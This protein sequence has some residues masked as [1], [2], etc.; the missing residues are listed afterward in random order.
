MQQHY[1][2]YHQNVQNGVDHMVIVSLVE[3]ALL[4][5]LFE[6]DERYMYVQVR[7][8][9]DRVLLKFVFKTQQPDQH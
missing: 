6:R 1:F 5:E 4:K 2:K 9:R 3:R 8:E 7:E